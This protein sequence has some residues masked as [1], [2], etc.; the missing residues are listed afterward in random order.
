MSTST[1]TPSCLTLE[2]EGPILTVRLSRPPVHAL[3][4][5]LCTELSAAVHDAER[6]EGVEGAG[7]VRDSTTSHVQP[8]DRRKSGR[9]RC[10]SALGGG[11]PGLALAGDH[12]SAGEP[13]VEG[14][15]RQ[16]GQRLD[17]GR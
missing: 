15:V 12:D 17:A 10:A 14:A 13:V 2:R 16:V 4:T 7:H 8:H 9:D 3:T 5:T 1:A 11:G 6:T